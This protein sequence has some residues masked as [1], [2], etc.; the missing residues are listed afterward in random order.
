[1]HFN[2]HDLKQFDDNTLICMDERVLRPLSIKL[3]ADL[4]E[5]R[6]RINQTSDN[7]S[8]PPGSDAP[9]KSATDKSEKAGTTDKDEK[10]D[11]TE[12]TGLPVNLD[13][14][15]A[16]SPVGVDAPRTPNTLLT[17]GKQGKPIGA[18]GFGRTQTIAP[19][20]TIYHYPC[21]CALCSAALDKSLAKSYTAWDEIDICKRDADT[22]GIQF[23]CTRH[24]Q[25]SIPCPCGHET[26]EEPYRAPDNPLWVKVPLGQW[27]LFGSIFAAHTVMF[28]YR[29]R[30]SYAKI[31]EF[32]LDVCGI[33]I[34]TGAINALIAEAG[35]AAEPLEA[36][37]I[38]EI[39]AA[40]IAYVDETSWKQSAKL[41]WLWVFVTGNTVLFSI[42]SRGREVF[43]RFMLTG[44]FT[45]KLMSDGYLVY[46]EYADRLRC[47][48]HLIRKA[49][50]LSDSVDRNVSA[51]GKA[52]FDIFKLLMVLI[53]EARDAKEGALAALKSQGAEKLEALHLLCKLHCESPH[54]KLREFSRELL[55][56]W[57]TIFC[58][59]HNPHLPLTNNAAERALRH[60]V[61]SRR[62]SY[63]TRTPAGSRVFTIL[64]SVFGTCRL[65][66]VAPLQFIGEV[67]AAAR[68]G[69]PL[70][71]LPMDKVVVV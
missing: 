8:R 61:I 47:W 19:T 48:A 26:R 3:L 54:K 4:R 62:I 9:W 12:N 46:R 41:Y 22:Y 50:G 1:M 14:E 10:S 16:P 44:R 38:Q 6:D 43:A 7:S 52:M 71:K 30:M 21:T 65:R 24:I 28:K 40:A 42:G 34:S 17:K 70:P 20:D 31:Q 32:W 59:V 35:R 51:T 45:G 39:E 13:H 66:N 64:A 36:E 27:H 37:L 55:Y 63:G 53:F 58:P 25:Q 2:D 60:W 18:K 5:S 49:Q 69:K 33:H 68:L 23:S 67:I 29:L 56:D 11:D 57:D 15:E